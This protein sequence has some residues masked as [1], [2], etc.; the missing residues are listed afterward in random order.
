MK[1]KY[2]LIIIIIFLLLTGFLYFCLNY[3]L[4]KERSLLKEE[5]TKNIQSIELEKPPFIKD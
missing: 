3:K 1:K 5:K 4:V 2:W